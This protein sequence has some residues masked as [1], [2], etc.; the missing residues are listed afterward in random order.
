MRNLF[1][2]EFFKNTTTGEKS[3]DLEIV[4]R[5]LANGDSVIFELLGLESY[6]NCGDESEL[7]AIVEKDGQIFLRHEFKWDDD[8]EEQDTWTRFDYPFFGFTKDVRAVAWYN[9]VIHEDLS[10]DTGLQSEKVK[11]T[12]DLKLVK[13]W[14]AEGKKLICDIYTL[15]EIM[16]TAR[17]LELREMYGVPYILTETG[18]K[19]ALEPEY[20]LFQREDIMLWPRAETVRIR[21]E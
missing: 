11:Y 5:W 12:R 21:N 16:H 19:Y 2:T 17:I 4:H 1:A 7:Q 6:F 10:E 14:L 3:R 13:Q 15:F 20:K 9:W 8:F 18:N